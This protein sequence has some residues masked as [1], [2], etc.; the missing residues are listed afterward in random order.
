MS[1]ENLI[2]NSLTKIEAWED[3]NIYNLTF[4]FGKNIVSPSIDTYKTPG[5]K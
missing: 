4:T 2:Q 5:K 3:Y 1:A